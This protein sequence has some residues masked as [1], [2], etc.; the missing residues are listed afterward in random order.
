MDSIR[1]AVADDHQVFRQGIAAIVSSMP[2]IELIAEAANGQELIEVVREKNPDVVLLDLRMPTLSGVDAAGLLRKE[3]PELKILVIS[4]YEEEEFVAFLMENGANGYLSKT[5]R[6]EIIENAIRTVMKDGLYL[7]PRTSQ[8][9]VR[10]LANKS[11]SKPDFPDELSLTKREYQVLQR[12]CE[13]MTNQEI[14]DELCISVRTVE[15]YR[16]DLLRKTKTRN[17]AGLVAYAFRHKLINY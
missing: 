16:N 7:D 13:S 14:A 5:E 1:L 10:Q 15:G 4:A 8:I 17:T 3:F 9:V 2:G 6:P 12:V 11:R